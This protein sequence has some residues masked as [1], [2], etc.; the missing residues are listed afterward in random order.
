MNTIR[1][2]VARSKIGPL[3]VGNFPAAINTVPDLDKMQIYED[4]IFSFGTAGSAAFLN[5]ELFKSFRNK[6]VPH[7]LIGYDETTSATVAQN[8]P[9]YV[10]FLTLQDSIVVQGYSRLKFFDKD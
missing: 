3:V 1:V 2:I 7:L 9:L 10:Y 4:K 8:N 6:K 5:T